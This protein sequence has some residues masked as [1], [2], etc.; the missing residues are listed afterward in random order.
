LNRRLL[1]FLL[2]GGLIG[3]GLLVPPPEGLT[4]QG[5]RAI[6]VMCAAILL[7]VFQPVELAVTAILGM[8]SIPLLGIVPAPQAFE[9]F[10]NQAVF[11]VMGVFMLA[12]VLVHTGLASRAAL[13]LL[14]RFNRS[15]T[16]LSAA[17][18]VI[19]CFSCA[20]LIS[21]IVAAILFPILLEILRALKLEHGR[22]RYA[23]RLLLSM[24]WGTIV[25]SNLTFFSSA[26]VGLAV[27][28]LNQ[29][30][31]K[32]RFGE[33]ISLHYWI[34]GA[35]PIVLLM[36][37]ITGALLGLFHRAETLDMR[38]ATELLKRRVEA[39]GPLRRDERIALLSL[40][41]MV[42]GMLLF[43]REVGFGSVALAAACLNFLSG[44]VSWSE[45]ERNIP[46]GVVFMFGGAIA[47]A[48]AIEH[49]GAVEWLAEHL[50][51]STR[52][53]PLVL[54]GVVA[55]VCVLM[56][57]FASNT[58][59]IAALLP[60]C[61]VLADG[62][63]L[64]ARTMVFASVIPAGLAFMLPT[65]TPAMALVFSSGYLRTRDTV[66]PGFLLVHVGWLVLMLVAAFFWPLIGLR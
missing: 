38:P 23:K 28:L 1:L 61:M 66:L 21:H 48:T 30:N 41:V 27:G 57:E 11:F 12:S 22:S 65:G 16:Q 40:V 9:L 59:V 44:S 56:T 33:G 14:G 53:H 49:T 5:F 13:S 17:V 6:L 25:G 58:A 62:I 32:A 31:E 19:S 7:W 3:L 64:P 60:V 45:A 34:L 43:G 2:A 63:N 15:P 39:L 4:V 52:V 47:M 8:S 42:G 24:A 50:L 36:L 10:A 37:G 29:H 51:P 54:I 18:L 46:W 26:R 20:F 55:Y 35:L